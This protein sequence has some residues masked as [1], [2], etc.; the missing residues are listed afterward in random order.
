MAASMCLKNQPKY[1]TSVQLQQTIFLYHSNWMVGIY[2]LLFF[3]CIM[4]LT[5][6]FLISS[7]PQIHIFLPFIGSFPMHTKSI[8][9]Y[10]HFL[11]YFHFQFKT[12]LGMLQENEND[13]DGIISILKSLQKYVPSYENSKEKPFW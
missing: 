6:I 10:Y 11:Q 4:A 1:M 8:F 13:A 12:F 5:I 2:K 7:L 3:Y 9:S